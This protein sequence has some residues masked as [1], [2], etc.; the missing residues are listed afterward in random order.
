MTFNREIYTHV[1]QRFLERYGVNM[2]AGMHQRIVDAIEAGQAILIAKQ[3]DQ[4]TVWDVVFDGRCFRVVYGPLGR[5]LLTVLPPEW[6]VWGL[7]KS[8]KGRHCRKE[9][10]R[11]RRMYA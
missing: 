3:S 8:N 5:Q 4:K 9:L 10:K 1:R 11:K 6:S 7:P 2:T